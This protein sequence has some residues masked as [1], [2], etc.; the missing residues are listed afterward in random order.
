M[1]HR[2]LQHHNFIAKNNWRM[3]ISGSIRKLESE[4]KNE[5]AYWVYVNNHNGP[6]NLNNFLTGFYPHFQPKK[7]G[8]WLPVYETTRN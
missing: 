2:Y 5:M 6:A 3:N 4:Y 8:L 1:E 7:H